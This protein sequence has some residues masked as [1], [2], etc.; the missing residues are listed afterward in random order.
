[1][2]VCPDEVAE[3][4]VSAVR[5]V[6]TAR[7]TNPAL[8]VPAVERG[9][10]GAGEVRFELLEPG[11][12]IP[13]ELP[14]AGEAGCAQRFLEIECSVGLP[15]S[16]SEPEPGIDGEEP[17]LCRRHGV[18]RPHFDGQRLIQQFRA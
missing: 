4:V 15:L 8:V 12:G 6:Q 3:L 2:T 9:I 1:M 17:A 16:D 11:P 18:L 7:R 14:C 10:L 13:D 5:I